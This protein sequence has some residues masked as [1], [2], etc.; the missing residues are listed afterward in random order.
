M[1]DKLF[2]LIALPALL[3][4]SCTDGNDTP[5]APATGLVLRTTTHAAAVGDEVKFIATL[6]G[7][8]LDEGYRIVD[9]RT[10]D[11]IPNPWEAASQ[12]EYTFRAEYLDE[13]SP[14]VDFKVTAT[15]KPCRVSLIHQFTGTW[16]SFCPGMTLGIDAYR[17]AYP[18]SLVVINVHWRDEMQA[19]LHSEAYKIHEMAGLGETVP[20]TWF[21]HHTLF[22]GAVTGTQKV[23]EML[24]RNRTAV[25]EATEGGCDIALRSHI[26]GSRIETTA[27][28]RFAAEG[29]YRICA[30][31][32]EDNVYPKGGA[33]ETVYHGVLREYATEVAG[34][35]VAYSPQAVEKSFSFD[36]SAYVPANCRVAVYV[37]RKHTDGNYY[38]CA[39]NDC[40]AEG[41]ADVVYE[42]S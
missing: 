16:C 32:L 39:A 42:Y 12:G 23:V 38:V 27:T 35:E 7:S 2:R 31:L 25:Q 20:A 10:G 18:R 15:K 9:T 14:E 40:F 34:D 17:K 33:N 29:D 5:P 37:L 24:R 6:G 28:L 8:R 13:T 11:A 22:N 30:A 26:A 36:A 21:D 1:F 19:T 41:E 3:A 4:A